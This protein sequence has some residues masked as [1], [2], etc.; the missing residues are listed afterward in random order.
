M[1]KLLL[2]ALLSVGTYSM[3]YGQK[4]DYSLVSELEQFYRNNDT[5]SIAWKSQIIK[6]LQFY[7]TN[8]QNGNGSN[9]F[10]SE[11]K[12]FENNIVKDSTD[13]AKAHKDLG[14]FYAK[15][16]V[17]VRKQER[18]KIQ[19]RSL[20]LFKSSWTIYK[21]YVPEN[22][23]DISVVVN[24]IGRHYI[25]VDKD[26][27][28]Y[29][30]K[31]AL[32]MRSM[33]KPIDYR[34]LGASHNNLGTVYWN[35]LDYETAYNYFLK[36]IEILKP[37]YNYDSP[38]VTNKILN[39]MV[40]CNDLGYFSEAIEYG[41]LIV[42]H[43]SR[44]RDL[45]LNNMGVAYLKTNN[46]D[47]A[48]ATF[49]EAEQ[50]IDPD[51]I[52]LLALVQSNL[53][54]AYTEN[55]NYELAENYYQKSNNLFRKMYG[56]YDYDYHSGLVS[57]AK[58]LSK[59]KQFQN[60]QEIFDEAI[61]FSEVRF[62]AEKIQTLRL[63]IEVIEFLVERKLYAEAL[64]KI[65]ILES[66][67]QQNF[68]T[69]DLD[70]LIR[71][72][73]HKILCLIK[74][75]GNEP[76]K[77]S[78]IEFA[79]QEMDRLLA[80]KRYNLFGALD[81]ITFNETLDHFFDL[82]VEYYSERCINDTSIENLSK[83]HI[84]IEEAKS[85]ALYMHS[86]GY[87]S[88]EDKIKDSAKRNRFSDLKTT[89][90][91]LKSDLIYEA[92]SSAY[93]SMK[94]RISE[95]MSQTKSLID[96]LQHENPGIFP[97][98]NFAQRKNLIQVQSELS[99]K[100]QLIN[101]YKTSSSIKVLSINRDTIQFSSIDIDS[102][103]QKH[104][105]Y[106]I[107]YTIKPMYSKDLLEDFKEASAYVYQNLLA[108]S[109]THKDEISNLII[110]PHNSLEQFPFDVL[111][112]K[113]ASKESSFKDL[114]YLLNKYNISYRYIS[115]S[116]P[117]STKDTY[118]K[119]SYGGFAPKYSASNGDS[120]A[121]YDLSFSRNQMLENLSVIDGRVYDEDECTKHNVIQ[122]ANDFKIMH[123]SS[124][125]QLEQ[126]DKSRYRLI[127]SEL[128]S[129]Y[130]TLSLEE[131][132]N[133]NLNNPLVILS[134]CNTG[135]GQ[136]IKGEGA[137]HLS[138]AFSFAGAQ[139][140]LMSFWNLSDQQTAIINKNFINYILQGKTKDIALQ[141]S[142]LQ[143]LKSS[144]ERLSHPY[145]WSGLAIIGDT[146]NIKIGKGENKYRYAFATLLIVVA[147]F[148]IKQIF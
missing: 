85:N 4:P 147:L 76:S 88:I 83:L 60:A 84:A 31:M 32:K 41:K 133:L 70:L 95:T 23:P 79:F 25:N 62:G 43:L 28:L 140:V 124:H 52:E 134:S 65:D 22:H 132:M 77:Q 44:N 81:Q 104:F 89:I 138:R 116:T 80:N 66:K 100:T 2:V 50:L 17:R 73:K 101:I 139:S 122:H 110:V 58:L 127:L 13:V 145:F 94:F 12:K 55:R 105:Q 115:E 51:Y 38:N 143:Y 111:L 107:D 98:W 30:F 20:Q 21:S 129:V 106:V 92:D 97:Y 59:K 112:T 148:F 69:D 54:D 39:L 102:I 14:D 15:Q 114:P 27:C 78:E 3:T 141:K 137:M 142:K 26:S 35:E 36:G 146:K 68:E 64:E 34:L 108:S 130:E 57:Y 117:K 24:R 37:H 53:G 33:Y 109:L 18:E 72:H 103:W 9:F 45:C 46:I 128:D 10:E 125:T 19:Q 126:D 86:I 135:V 87:Q 113:D 123:L 91:Q 5:L 47:L 49:R 136:F 99:N 42:P 90:R 82:K 63:H 120:T 1:Y 131:I 75:G 48:I 74:M 7:A 67:G 144:S 121:F 16:I 93:L 61:H 8:I 6:E 11:S 56:P 96:S 118:A 29:Y 40:V 71:L 119:K